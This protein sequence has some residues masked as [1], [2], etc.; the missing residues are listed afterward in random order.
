MSADCPGYRQYDTRRYSYLHTSLKTESRHRVN[1]VVSGV[2]VGCYKDNLRCHQRRQDWHNDMSGVFNEM[3]FSKII[4][5][6]YYVVWIYLVDIQINNLEI[7]VHLGATDIIR[8]ACMHIWILYWVLRGTR[9]TWLLGATCE[10]NNMYLI[11][12]VYT[13]ENCKNT[14]CEADMIIKS[15]T[16]FIPYSIT[17]T[18]TNVLVPQIPGD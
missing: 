15:Y 3:W 14:Y 5:N 7:I 9:K 10:S 6:I 11:V 8:A 18:S 1:F 17:A 13:D 16:W 2:I 4:Y 12:Y